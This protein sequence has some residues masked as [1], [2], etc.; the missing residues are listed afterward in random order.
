MKKEDAQPSECHLHCSL[1]VASPGVPQG[2]I[3]EAMSNPTKL[4]HVKIFRM[5]PQACELRKHPGHSTACL[6]TFALR[7]TFDL[8]RFRQLQAAS[9]TLIYFSFRLFLSLPLSKVAIR[10]RSHMH[11]LFDI[12][13]N[14]LSHSLY[15]Y[16]FTVLT[17][18]SGFPWNKKVLNTTHF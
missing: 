5:I 9:L 16:L 11:I 1:W 7:K 14:A 15:I 8:S 2:T 4:L 18:H 10:W 17:L 13:W 12:L 6:G 3:H